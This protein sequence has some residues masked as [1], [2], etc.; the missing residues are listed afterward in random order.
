MTVP[1]PA[2][3]PTEIPAPTPAAPADPA[4][5]AQETDWKTKYEETIAESRKWESQ[6]KANK[7]AAD[8]LTALKAAQMTETEKS[9][10]RLAELETENQGYK[11]S[12]QV[13]TWKA[14]VSKE[15]GVPVAA[16]AGSSLEDIQ[17][18]AEVLKTMLITKAD[19]PP[20][21]DGKPHVP[22]RDLSKVLAD[23]PNPLPG[24]GTLRAA[25]ADKQ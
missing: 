11:T 7:T 18:H 3:T 8:E 12:A 22:Y 4:A 16:L 20:V 9:A 5:P 6:S 17:A 1:T 14:D 2:P 24:I 25:Y 19:P 21:D 23:A 15:T 10:A 13:A